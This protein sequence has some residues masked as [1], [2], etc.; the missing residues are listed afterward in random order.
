VHAIT[1]DLILMALF[2]FAL[3]GH[4]RIAQ[5]KARGTRAAALGKGHIKKPFEP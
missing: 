4:H 2:I 3:K 1:P 5:G